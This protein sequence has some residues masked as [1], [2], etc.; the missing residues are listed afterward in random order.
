MPRGQFPKESSTAK[1]EVGEYRRNMVQHHSTK[2]PQSGS[3]SVALSSASA[4]PSLFKTASSTGGRVAEAPALEPASTRTSLHANT[5][6]PSGPEHSGDSMLAA[7][8]VKA[9]KLVTCAIKSRSHAPPPRGL[10]RVTSLPDFGA[11]GGNGGDGKVWPR[12]KVKTRWSLMAL[13]A[14]AKRVPFDEEAGNAFGQK[15]V[16]MANDGGTCVLVSIGH[17]LGLFSAMAKLNDRPRSAASIARAANNL[18]TRYVEELLVAMTCVGIVEESVY[19]VHPVTPAPTMTLAAQASA[20]IG[21]TASNRTGAMSSDGRGGGGGTSGI[22]GTTNAA[23]RDGRDVPIGVMGLAGGSSDGMEHGRRKYRLP[24]EHALFLTWQPGADNLAL[25]SQYVPILG[26]L[27]A[28]VVECFR[29]GAGMEWTR[30][31]QFDLVSELDTAQ[32]IGSMEQF[33]SEVLGQ[34]EG[35]SADMRRGINVVCVGCG[36][37]AGLV[38]I[39]R[40]TCRGKG[41]VQRGRMRRARRT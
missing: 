10:R 16:S 7:A 6:N 12:E 5:D 11:G 9:K 38:K 41:A 13:P 28:E 2:L 21:S 4:W 20:Y 24:A 17:Q 31:G 29:T 40:T 36:V 32:T 1:T 39:A 18:S 15:I 35:L 14:E 3:D 25:V 27:E 23:A 22:S 34:V 26:R 8:A 19:P 30:Y 33:D 37:G